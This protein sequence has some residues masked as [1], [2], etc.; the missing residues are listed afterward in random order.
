MPDPQTSVPVDDA[1]CDIVSTRVFDAPRERVFAAFADPVRLARWWGP[2]GFKNTFHEFEFHPA[3][4]WRFIMHGP[5]GVDYPNH[6][7]FRSIDPPVRIV[8]DHMSAPRFRM[9][10]VLAQE[11][12]RTRI[13]WTQHFESAQLR[14]QVAQFAVLANEQNFDRLWAELSAAP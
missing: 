2:S 1:S 9:T 12:A 4:N 10:I 5:D 8:L 14:D 3:G 7:V 13:T 11:A 6:S